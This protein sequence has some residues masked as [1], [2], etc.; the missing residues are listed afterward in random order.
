MVSPTLA[1]QDHLKS[2]VQTTKCDPTDQTAAGPD[3]GIYSVCRVMTLKLSTRKTHLIAFWLQYDLNIRE[4]LVV[5]GHTVMFV[6][7]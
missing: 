4:E 6:Q 1:S 7:I 3:Q 2:A 5:Y